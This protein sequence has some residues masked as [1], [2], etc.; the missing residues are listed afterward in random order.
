[1]RFAG[2]AKIW[3]VIVSIAMTILGI[4]MVVHPSVTIDMLC[5]VTGIVLLVGGIVKI[6]NFASHS[7]PAFRFDIVAGVVLCVIGLLFL[8]IP[9]TMAS[10]LGIV[11][12][13][14][15]FVEGAFRI[16]TALDA[17][18]F[19]LRLWWLILTAAVFMMLCGVFIAL[20]P[21]S[22]ESVL[23][24]FL[25][26]LLIIDGVQNLFNAIYTTKMKP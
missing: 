14:F 26:I 10:I 3:Y 15:I 20:F 23:I 22:A 18:W 24:T 12:G 9:Q 13:V 25:G 17:R 11:F 16:R 19:G 6:A 2:H 8:L 7:S 21:F 1:M 5:I 4:V